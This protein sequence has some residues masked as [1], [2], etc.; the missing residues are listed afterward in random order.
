[1]KLERCITLGRP[2]AT[3][4]HITDANEGDLLP[5]LTAL[6]GGDFTYAAVSVQDWN[7]DLSPWEAPPVFGRTP[8]GGQAAATLKALE[9]ELLPQFDPDLPRIL[10]GYSLAGLFALWAQYETGLFDGVVAA[11]PSV[12][13]PGWDA[14]ADVHSPRGCAYLSLGDR[15][16]HT[17][18]RQM[19]TV[20]DAI[21]RQ[22][23][24]FRDIPATLEWNPGNH[25]T[26][27][28]DRTAR[29]FAWAVDRITGGS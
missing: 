13:Y 6:L 10:G 12:W 7:R 18:N 27:P 26:D 9:R 29:G 8:F 28:E 19:A 15:E 2:R 17:R 20:A 25:F 4:I 16:A 22:A 5:P 3:L 11:S 24:R 14:Y 21:R 1:M 23:G